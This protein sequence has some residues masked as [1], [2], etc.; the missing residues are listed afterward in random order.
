MKANHP[1]NKEVPYRI[2]VHHH[3]LPKVY[4]ETLERVGKTTTFGVVLPGWSLEAHLERQFA[5]ALPALCLGV[6]IIAWLLPGFN[7]R[8]GSCNVPG[9]RSSRSESMTHRGY[10]C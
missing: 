6:R 10:S 3:V 5:Q 8:K 2:D 9:W 1:V 4:L 7:R